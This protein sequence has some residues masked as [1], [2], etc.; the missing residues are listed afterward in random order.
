M[1]SAADVYAEQLISRRHGLPLWQPEPTKF[2]EVL[3]GDVGFVQ[4]GC[5]Y[6]L[7]NA[8]KLACDPINAQCGVPRDFVPL[9]YN[10]T[11]L[12]HTV[13]DYLP[14]GPLYSASMR[15]IAFGGGAST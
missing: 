9:R 2:G 8:T 14:P 11:A 15:R 7:F 12:L 6:R 4:N 3:I 13:D 1:T 5:F 10:E